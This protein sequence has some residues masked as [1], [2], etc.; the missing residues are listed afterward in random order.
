MEITK[1][2]L[3]EQNITDIQNNDRIPTQV[4]A[5]KIEEEK[6]KAQRGEGNYA[7]FSSNSVE[8]VDYLDS[9]NLRKAIEKINEEDKKTATY[10][11]DKK[12][13]FYGG[14]TYEVGSSREYGANVLKG[15]DGKFH[16]YTINKD[17]SLTIDE[18]V[19]V[20]YKEK[21]EAQLK[22]D[23]ERDLKERQ[24]QYN[25]EQ[26]E[27]GNTDSM[28]PITEE[29]T[30]KVSP[31]TERNGTKTEQNGTK[32]E[33]TTPESKEEIKDKTKTESKEST[34]TDDKTA[35]I[36]TREVKDNLQRNQFAQYRNSLHPSTV[37]AILSKNSGLS[38]GE[39][40]S[41]ALKAIGKLTGNAFLA[42]GMSLLG[43]NSYFS[44]I[45]EGLD[46]DSMTSDEQKKVSDELANQIA[47]EAVDVQANKTVIERELA[48][49]PQAKK[50]YLSASAHALISL[51]PENFKA[52]LKGIKIKDPKTKEIITFTD[53]EINNIIKIKPMLQNNSKTTRANQSDIVDTKAKQRDFNFGNFKNAADKTKAIQE[54]EAYKQNLIQSKADITQSNEIDKQIEAFQKYASA[55][56][57]IGSS[58]YTSSQ[59]QNSAKQSSSQWNVSGSVGVNLPI[60][61]IGVTG[62][63]GHSWG[64]S[65]AFG[66]NDGKS[67]TFNENYKFGGEK[68]KKAFE[69]WWGEYGSSIQDELLNSIDERIKDLDNDIAEIRA[70]SVV[71]DALIPNGEIE[72]IQLKDGS[73]VVPNENDG[74]V[75]TTNPVS[76]SFLTFGEGEENPFD[77]LG[78]EGKKLTQEEA[79]RIF[80]KEPLSDYESIMAY[81]ES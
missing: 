38:A 9:N 53:D 12:Q 79:E 70:M 28:I 63:G 5:Q 52:Q 56:G 42:N 60:A 13:I 74:A 2:E 55:Y 26:K 10:S 31:K 24:E 14:K 75:L 17:G 19:A 23:Q 66:T 43:D 71:D 77:Y 65:T 27:L 3:L 40:V 11:K 69:K 36:T 32:T 8:S 67:F 15:D 50:D 41:M 64:D 44:K 37:G 20:S 62:G 78:Y 80:D 54:L 59:S 72:S 35:E 51:S 61:N 58:S 22:A 4:K 6:R 46:L 47:S 30:P 45:G 49:M 39:R 21:K 68:G 34:T 18:N 1:D 76:D 73:T 33:T 57:G 81:L 29:E 16:K 48:E 25:K 7:R